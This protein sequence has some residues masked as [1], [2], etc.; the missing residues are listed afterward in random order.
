MIVKVQPLLRVAEATNSLSKLSEIIALIAECE[1]SA[2]FYTPRIYG[3]EKGL[4][5]RN[6]QKQIAF[7]KQLGIEHFFQTAEV[8]SVQYPYA[9]SSLTYELGYFIEPWFENH[10]SLNKSVID[11][12]ENSR[13]SFYSSVIQYAELDFNFG[14]NI[15]PLTEIDKI[16]YGVEAEEFSTA[17][18]KIKQQIQEGNTYQINFTFPVSFT[19]MGELEDFISELVFNQSAEFIALIKNGEKYILSISPEL[20]LQWDEIGIKAKPMKGTRSRG[21]TLQADALIKEEL[22][23]SEKDKAE[24]VMIVDLLRNDIGKIC[25]PGS[26]SVRSLFDIETYETL[27][28]MTSTIV[29]SLKQGIGL[30]EVLMSTFPCGSITGAPKISSMEIIRNVEKHIRGIYTGSIGLKREEQWTFNVAIR[31]LEIKNNKATMGIGSG[32]VWDS[33][34]NLEYDEILSK[35][36]FIANRQSP[37]RLIETMLV[38]HSSI[39]LLNYHT[40]RLKNSSNYFRFSF[41]EE[42]WM[43]FVRTILQNC[44]SYQQYKLRITL[45][46]Q[47]DF[48]YQ[49]T[50][51]ENTESDKIVCYSDSKISSNSVYQYFKTTNREQYDST[52]AKINGSKF[53]DVIFLNERE[54]VVEGSFNNIIIKKD[55]VYY[56]PPILSG[57]LPG[58]YRSFLIETQGVIEKVLYKEDIKNADSV[59]LC[60]AVRGRVKVIV[61]DSQVF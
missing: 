51:I 49:L 52:I 22:K 55:G 50:P 24:N 21:L 54:E 14:T 16:T 18:Q 12:A 38:S 23:N 46:K 42:K 57:A 7:S 60:N 34:K 9:V 28:Q 39:A 30:T 61:E 53:Y 6:P 44:S 1:H 37:F 4:L 8:Y 58:V 41:V 59:F 25:E 19:I 29:G 40:E 15:K 2:F 33:K 47:G 31:T 45:S 10:G 56:T 17:I 3:E 26:V 20:F 11:S 36:S 35:F 5:F 43:D 27:H 48:D 13:F 32:I